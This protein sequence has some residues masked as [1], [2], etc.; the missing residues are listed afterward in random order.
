[1]TT[2]I[3][4]L[5]KDLKLLATQLRT[6]DD[7]TALDNIQD[8]LSKLTSNP[9]ILINCN[10]NM[11]SNIIAAMQECQAKRDWLGLADY[12]EYDLIRV[13]NPQTKIS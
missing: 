5:A 6:N 11:I 13:I 12:L 10:I 3:D 1:M 7:Y 9:D 2:Q 4:D 8:V